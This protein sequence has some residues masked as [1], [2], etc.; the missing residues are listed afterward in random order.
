MYPMKFLNVISLEAKMI[1][2]NRWLLLGLMLF[3]LMAWWSFENG[4]RIYTYQHAAADSVYSMN[5]KNWAS[6]KAQLD[7]LDYSKA[8][9]EAIETPFTLDWRLKPMVNRK[10]HPL[11][12]L[13]VG[14]N[15]ILVLQKS[16]RITLPVFNNDF[17]EFKNPEQLQAGSFDMG[18]YLLFLFPLLFMALS[19]NIRSS[20]VESCIWT[21]WQS[22]A[23]SQSEKLQWMRL[24]FRWVVALV[25]FLLTMVFAYFWMRQ[26]EGFSGTEFRAWLG[27]AGLYA[28]IWCI[29]AGVVLRF[30]MNSM[31]NLLSLLGIW[32]LLLVAIP[33]TINLFIH[34]DNPDSI[35]L[36]VAAF[37]DVPEDA[38]SAPLEVH[39]EW[40]AKRYPDKAK[41]TGVA[42]EAI[43]KT[44]SY[45]SQTM[46]VEEKLHDR[47]SE[48]IAVQIKKENTSFLI[49]PAGYILRCFTTLAQSDQ[50]HQL[51]FERKLI[52][53]RTQRFFY[54]MDN[55]VKD[56]HFRPKDLETM[57][58]WV[59]D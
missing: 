17:E 58:A 22:A 3:T 19:H 13:T 33:G 44:F 23:Q 41:D 29:I 4:K 34:Q 51:A 30:K 32:V 31:Q 50:Q 16:A 9:R 15:D 42:A 38:W 21:Q 26:K 20:E 49:N 56:I 52:E 53:Y 54:L 55:M 43:I 14:Q 48:N 5:K 25:P 6:V 46:D 35:R 40:F 47:F 18:F 36:D 10:L 57:P 24:A 59:N 11:S 1:L 12:A 45:L 8:E 37:R 28:F 2:R 27:Y 39:R 7:T